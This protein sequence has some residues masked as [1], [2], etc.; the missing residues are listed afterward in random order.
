M[1]AFDVSYVFLWLGVCVLLIGVAALYSAMGALISGQLRGRS[2]IDLSGIGPTLEHRVDVP[3]LTDLEGR[4]V[5]ALSQRWMFVSPDCPGCKR[6]RER[7]Q[8]S[9][10]DELPG[11]VVVVCRGA[12]DEALAWSDGAPPWASI[13]SNPAGELFSTFNVTVTPF[14]VLLNRKGVCIG[15]GPAAATIYA[16]ANGPAEPKKP[17]APALMSSAA[18]HMPGNG[19]EEER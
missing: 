19:S 5:D 18:A 12:P 4:A 14:Y 9:T 10:P 16:A 2:G 8:N 17:R 3:D 7:L 6:A 11:G 15:K 13:V 1:S